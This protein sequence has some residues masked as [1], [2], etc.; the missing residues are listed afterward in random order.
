MLSDLAFGLAKFGNDVHVICSRQCY[1]DAKAN[2]PAEELV[3][4]VTVHR[5][6]TTQFGRHNILGR[7]IDYLSFYLLAFFMLLRHVSPATILV[8]KTDPPLIAVPAAFV[9]LIRRAKLVNWIQDLFPEVAQ[10]AGVPGLNGLGGQVIKLVRNWSVRR[11][12]INIVI[13]ERMRDVVLNSGARPNNVRIIPNWQDTSLIRPVKA[14][15]N[16]LIDKWGLR[17]KFVLMYSGNLGRAHDFTTMLAAMQ[18]LKDDPRFHF[19][20]IGG[21]AQMAALRHEVQRLGLSNFSFHPYQPRENLALSLSA[22]SVHLISLM[23]EQEGLIVPSKYYGIMASGRPVIF[24]GDQDG[25]LAREIQREGVG[26]VV[27]IGDSARLVEIVRTMQTD[28]GKSEA[29]GIRARQIAE[30]KY[31]PQHAAAAWNALFSN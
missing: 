26:S 12:T 8:A 25:E 18:S 27:S 4:G 16:P 7:L 17:G 3:Q 19:S 10:K 21:G 24:I 14:D 29:L 30:Q 9:A 23:P 15:H 5:I 6:W 22:A 11:A 20:C 28:P 2:L 13:G 31:A 1:E